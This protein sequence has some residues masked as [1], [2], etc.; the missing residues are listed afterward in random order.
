MTDKLSDLME[1]CGPGFEI[2]RCSSW[3]KQCSSGKPW[4]ASKTY[5]SR[6]K[7]KKWLRL[8][9]Q[10]E[11]AEEAVLELWKRIQDFEDTV[12]S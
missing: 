11:T 1:Q 2:I 7:P 9:A 4:V 8:E 6:K 3:G 10:A 12:Q 5:A